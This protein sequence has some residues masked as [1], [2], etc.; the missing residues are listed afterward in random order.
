MSNRY[1]IGG[2][3]FYSQ[4]AHWSATSG[5]S[6][7]ETVPTSSDDV[8]I[9]ANSGFDN[10]NQAVFIGSDL[11]EY[12]SNTNY[13][14]NFQVDWT[15]S[16]GMTEWLFIFR[17]SDTNYNFCKNS[18]CIQFSGTVIYLGY[19]TNSVHTWSDS[20]AITPSTGDVFSITCIDN[21]VTIY[22]NSI[23]ITSFV[24]HYSTGNCFGF[25]TGHTSFVGIENLIFS[26]T[27]VP[28]NTAIFPTN[29]TKTRG[30]TVLMNGG[31]IIVDNNYTVNNLT[32]D[33]IGDSFV[34]SVYAGKTLTFNGTPLFNGTVGNLIIL[35]I[36]SNESENQFTFS[37]SSGIVKCNYLDISNSNATGGATWHAGS[38]S[39]D[40]VGND[41]WIFTDMTHTVNDNFQ[42]GGYSGAYLYD[43]GFKYDAIPP[44]YYD[45]GLQTSNIYHAFG[46]SKSDTFTLADSEI[47]NFGFVTNDTL[48]LAD[49]KSITDLKVSSDSVSITESEVS[50]LGL[51][52][53]ESF[54]LTDVQTQGL[55]TLLS[56]SQSISDSPAF[57]VGIF[58]N[59]SLYITDSKSFA[60]AIE[61]ADQFNFDTLNLVFDNTLA[62]SDSISLSDSEVQLFRLT[63]TDVLNMVDSESQQFAFIKAK[64]AMIENTPTIDFGDN[65]VRIG[66]DA[67]KVE[68]ESV[69]W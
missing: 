2:T 68:V 24:P 54:S 51:N 39:N 9:D 60:W 43:S 16:S 30:E 22:Q 62:L 3:G 33:E 53:A 69:K 52:I 47:F 12:H 4:I 67:I 38:H 46:L 49:A 36:T 37:K 14:D 25:Y 44:I 55:T 64:I 21:L 40:T 7:G 56:D 1:W 11:S 59:D 13:S 28:A 61:L 65:P 26:Q 19:A 17:G 23:E 48:Y 42:I 29:F 8:F 6:G 34:F 20:V 58:F 10:L 57:A 45:I 15:Y 41:G 5:G 27:S 31:T 66:V 35:D 18:V 50:N 32:A 63:E